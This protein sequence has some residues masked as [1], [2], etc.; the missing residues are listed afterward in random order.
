MVQGP[1]K[2]SHIAQL[3]TGERWAVE[4]GHTV[5]GRFQDL[6]VSADKVH[7]FDR[8]DLKPWLAAD[9]LGDWDMIVWSK[10]DRAFRST[11]DC[12]QFGKWAKDNRK[13][14]VF[15]EDGLTLNFRE[16]GSDVESMMSELF[17]YLG[18]FF[19][20]LELNRFRTRALDGHRV[21]RQ[22]DRWASGIP[23]LGYRVVDHPSGKGKGLETDPEGKDLLY[24]MA[25]HLLSGWSFTRIAEWLN[26]TKARTNM[27]RAKIANGK[28]P[29]ARPWTTDTVI[30]A[31]TSPKTQGVKMHKGEPVLTGDGA[32]IQLAPPTFDID[33]WTQIQAAAQERRLAGRRR[34]H[35]SNPMLGIGYCA[36]CGASLAQQVSRRKNKDNE[37]KVHRYYRCGRTPIN[38]QGVTIRADLAD[39]IMAET[40]LEQWGDAEV[41]R[42]VFVPG[43]DHSHELEQ[44]VQTI[45]RLRRESDAGLIVSAEDERVYLERMRSLI[46]RRSELEQ[47]P[48]RSAGWKNETTGQTY[49]EVWESADDHRGLLIDAGI[50]FRLTSGTPMMWA[51]EVPQDR[52]PL[53]REPDKIATTT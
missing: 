15:A 38:C 26:H 11:Y 18:S 35:T 16:K 48:S 1:Q 13:V 6:D 24:Q 8:P 47:R 52:I 21:L 17:V 32:M 29:K 37:T 3:E 40:F 33:T 4:H 45:E 23:P 7:T 27:D 44:V 19:A 22:T 5:V 31:L 14:V 53:D 30:G 25:G 43:E 50:R 49:H 10:V 36:K 12:V 42:R 2:V 20:Q 34:S 28:S 51:L 46:D 39:Q 41:T 9:R